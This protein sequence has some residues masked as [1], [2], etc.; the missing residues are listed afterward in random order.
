MTVSRTMVPL[1]GEPEAEF[2]LGDD[3][4]GVLVDTTGGPE[5]EVV[6]VRRGEVVGKEPVI[7]GGECLVTG[8]GVM[9]VPPFPAIMGFAVWNPT[10]AGAGRTGEKSRTVSA[11]VS[12]SKGASKKGSGGRGLVFVPVLPVA[13][14]GR[15]HATT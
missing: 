5:L 6:D 11:S 9:A 2:Y 8:R 7:V 4:V 13:R 14:R 15:V 3:E 10:G 12:G 1:D